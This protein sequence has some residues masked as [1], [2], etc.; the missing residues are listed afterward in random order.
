MNRCAW[1]PNDQTSSTSRDLGCRRTTSTPAAS[2][3]ASCAWTRT[4]RCTP[5]S[6]RCLHALLPAAL[7]LFLSAAY[8][9]CP[10]NQRHPYPAPHTL[11]LFH[12]AGLI[13]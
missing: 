1:P 6:A 12:V 13:P 4:R 10:T 9:G 3:F 7:A 8:P 2:Q 11:S 5:K